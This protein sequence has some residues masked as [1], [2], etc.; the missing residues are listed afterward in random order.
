M[1]TLDNHIANQVLSWKHIQQCAR[2]VGFDA[3]GIAPAGRLDEDA[4]FMERWIAQGLHGN[5]TYLERNTEKRYDIRQLTNWKRNLAISLYR[6]NT[7]SV[8]RHPCWNGNG[9]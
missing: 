9:R 4:T 2:E 5:M 7:S 6:H 8:T 1:A 3:C